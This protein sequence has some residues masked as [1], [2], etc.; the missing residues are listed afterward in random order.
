MSDKSNIVKAY[1]KLNYI[2]LDL[3]EDMRNLVEKIE[4]AKEAALDIRES[5]EMREID[6][7]ATNLE[8]RSGGLTQ[9]DVDMINKIQEGD[10]VILE[11]SRKAVELSQD[12]KEIADNLEQRAEKVMEDVGGLGR[13]RSI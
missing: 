11:E 4:I 10:H 8:E 12:L 1:N 13:D 3:E 5:N 9:E 7:L 6:E 2:N